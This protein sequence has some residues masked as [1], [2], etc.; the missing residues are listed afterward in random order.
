MSSCSPKNTSGKCHPLKEGCE[1]SSYKGIVSCYIKKCRPDESLKFYAS[2][3][4]INKAVEKASHAKAETGKRHPH[5]R[6]IPKKVLDKVEKRL[7]TVSFSN[8]SDFQGLYK[9]VEA[10]IAGIRGVGE[11]MVYDTA[12]RIGACLKVKVAPE[13]VYLHAGTRKGA[14]AILG[15]SVLKVKTL[16]MSEFPKEF[17]KLSPH[18]VEDCLCIYKDELKKLSE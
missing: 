9:K 14:E 18:E 7:K 13:K 12:L 4:D 11:L 16:D 3:E 15:K 17:K 1:L 5:Q 8:C 6:R 10:E 2:I